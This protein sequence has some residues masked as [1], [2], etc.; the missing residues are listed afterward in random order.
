MTRELV[1]DGKDKVPASTHGYFAAGLNAESSGV[2]GIHASV[3]PEVPAKT[4]AWLA[5]NAPQELNG[6]FYVYCQPEITKLVEA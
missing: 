4:F 6:N 5:L 2:T 1:R 3:S